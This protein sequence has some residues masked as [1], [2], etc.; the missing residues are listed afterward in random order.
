MESKLFYELVNTEKINKIICNWD[1]LEPQL[2]I[3]FNTEEKRKTKVYQ[4]KLLYTILKNYTTQTG[5]SYNYGSGRID[6]RLYGY[7]LQGLKR[8]F[9]EI[10]CAEYYT[11]IDMKNA[12]PVILRAWCKKQNLKMPVLVEYCE[13][14][15]S[16]Y[17][18]KQPIIEI[19]FGSKV[20]PVESQKDID[21]M[22]ELEQEMKQVY[23]C[24]MN[25]KDYQKKINSLKKRKNKKYNV[26]G[27]LCSYI[28][29]QYESVILEKTLLFLEERGIPLKYVVMIFDG[30]MLPN[31]HYTPELLVDINEYIFKTL[32][33]DLYIPATF[34]IKPMNPIDVSKL[35]VDEKELKKQ[36]K[37]EWYKTTKD[38]LE[39]TLCRITQPLQYLI[40]DPDT[41]SVY[42]LAK[43]E[44]MERFSERNCQGSYFI[45]DWLDDPT[46]RKYQSIDFLPPPKVCPEN[47][48]NLW[49]G[50]EIESTDDPIDPTIGE[51]LLKKLVGIISGNHSGME[52]Y[53]MNILANL[54][55]RPADPP[56]IS[57][58]ITG[59]EGT[60]KNVFGDLLKVLIGKKYSFETA[61][62]ENEVFCRFKYNVMNKLLLII[63]EANEHETFKYEQKLKHWIGN[64]KVVS[65]ETKGNKPI[66]IPLYMFILLITNNMINP[67]PLTATDRRYTISVCSEEYRMNETFFGGV[68]DTLKE[69]ENIKAMFNY[70]KVF[71]ITIKNWGTERPI[72]KLYRKIQAYCFE[73][74][75]KGF[76][77]L[78][79]NDW[80]T[81]ENTKWY[82]N[83]SLE[84][85]FNMTKSDNLGIKIRDKVSLGLNIEAKKQNQMRGW[86]INRTEIFNWLKDK[87][88]IYPDENIDPKKCGIVETEVETDD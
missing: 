49:S 65:I 84:I 52:T 6:G 36:I 47:I 60:G 37:I 44:L 39:K 46:K 41:K 17:H 28:L 7:G 24:M 10:I 82:S 19:I 56:P 81:S 22:L 13:N 12:Q 77:Q 30:F 67:V 88:Y 85:E 73:K 45:K 64:G 55:Q 5:I 1:T 68:V 51:N 87:G 26:E 38:E 63:N 76:R 25:H 69:L 11:D 74:L 18:L 54:I 8:A 16:Y 72:T 50:F 53:I 29:E 61:D 34:L 59:L 9:R 42:I 21:F 2:N 31:E 71:P 3:E 86:L 33:N 20:P 70:L 66:D 57:L 14:R 75:V 23:H 27:S 62:L 48:Y 43:N 4:K 40:L 15:D 83:E 80:D 79:L 58:V 35:S 32:M 78:I